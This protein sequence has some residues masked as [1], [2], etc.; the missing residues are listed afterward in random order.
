M[1][2]LAKI[3]PSGWLDKIFIT[4]VRTPNGVCSRIIKLKPKFLSAVDDEDDETKIFFC[5][6]P[7]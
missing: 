1:V 3:Q 2:G 4:A 7:L 6:P 5:Y